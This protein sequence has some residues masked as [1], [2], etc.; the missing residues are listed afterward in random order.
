M[1]PVRD[2]QRDD[3]GQVVGVMDRRPGT[4]FTQ[5]TSDAAT[6]S[7][8]MRSAVAASGQV[9]RRTRMSFWIIG[10]GCSYG[11][12]RGWRRDPGPTG[13]PAPGA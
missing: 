2:R 3:L 13:D 8:A 9:L 12:R 11:I 5:A 6:S 4:T 10:L 7:R 1:M